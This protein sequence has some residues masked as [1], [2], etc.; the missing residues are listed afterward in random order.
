VTTVLQYLVIAA[1]IA[2]LLFG[3]SLL[4]FGRGERLAALP[5][6][7][8]PAQLPERGIEGADVRR[9]RFALALRGYRMSDVDW[10]LDRL[11]D[12]LDRAR[13]E[14][15]E[16]SATATPTA[17]VPQD[18]GQTD[19]GEHNHSLF[20]HAQ[21]NHTGPDDA[22]QRHSQRNHRGPNDAAPPATAPPDTASPDTASPDTAFPAAA[23]PGSA[24]AE[25]TAEL[26]EAQ[27]L[28][29]F[30]QPRA[31]PGATPSRPPEAATADDRMEPAGSSRGGQGEAVAPAPPARSET[32][33]GAHL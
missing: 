28:G 4:L 25:P 33:P 22:E 15:A 19:G 27:D 24:P 2:L 31:V 30:R 32:L 6:R 14:L 23:F 7:T 21:L 29:A 11:A 10:T 8:S 1:V 17:A 20:D 9:V 18:V 13:R 3:L 5:A 12:E 26:D 16:V